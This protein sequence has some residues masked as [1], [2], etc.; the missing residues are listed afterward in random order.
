ML[1]VYVDA[2]VAGAGGVDDKIGAEAI[3]LGLEDSSGLRRAVVPTLAKPNYDRYSRLLPGSTEA[4]MLELRVEAVL[5]FGEPPAA[6][7]V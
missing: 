2:A 3:R 4:K 7:K 1:S 5:E 6:A